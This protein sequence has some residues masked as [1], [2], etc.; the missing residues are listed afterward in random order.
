M[1]DPQKAQAAQIWAA[2]EDFW[3]IEVTRMGR[4]F[5][6]ST[7]VLFDKKTK[8][9]CGWFTEDRGPFYCPLDQKTYISFGFWDFLSEALGDHSDVARAYVLSHEYGHHIMSILGIHAQMLDLRSACPSTKKKAISRM[10]EH[11]ADALA[12]YWMKDAY[13]KLKISEG[14][15]LQAAEVASLMGD[16]NIYRMNHGLPAQAAVPSENGSHGDGTARRRWFL[17]GFGSD[18]IDEANAFIDRTLAEDFTPRQ[19]KR[20]KSMAFEP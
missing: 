5:Q 17:Q 9:S 14:E 19:K 18:H 6:P 3:S 11:T 16:D 1:R 10:C 15:V 7:L 2:L 12:G 13:H 8:T 4:R 20:L